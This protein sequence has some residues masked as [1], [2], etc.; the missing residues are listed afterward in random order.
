[1]ATTLKRWTEEALTDMARPEEGV[2]FF[3][4][5]LAVASASPEE[6]FLAPVWEQAFRT[7]KSPLL[8]LEDE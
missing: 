3:F 4:C 5:S 7:A 2:R 8:V 1:M 6:L